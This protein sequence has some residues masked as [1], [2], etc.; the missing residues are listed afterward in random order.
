DGQRPVI[1]RRFARND[2]GLRLTRRG[3]QDIG[4]KWA[5]IRRALAWRELRP[6]GL[7][8]DLVAPHRRRAVER[9]VYVSPIIAHPEPVRLPADK[10]RRD[11]FAGDRVEPGDCVTSFSRSARHAR[12]DGV[13][14]RVV[15]EVVG[16]QWHLADAKSG[17]L[18]RGRA[19]SRGDAKAIVNR[20]QATESERGGSK[21]NQVHVGYPFTLY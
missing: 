18:S 3:G 4:I 5:V 7:C 20:S 16:R 12:K 10:N 17:R 6:C 2:D 19:A 11:D 9:D 21:S 15:N 8:G 14:R 13:A 1:A